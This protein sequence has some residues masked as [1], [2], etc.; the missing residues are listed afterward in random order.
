MVRLLKMPGGGFAT[1]HTGEA[2]CCAACKADAESWPAWYAEH[3]P[4]QWAAMQAREAQKR[5]GA[6]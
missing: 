5:G 2:E 1:V 3:F 4:E 6:A